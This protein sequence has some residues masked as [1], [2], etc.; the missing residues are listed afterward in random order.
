MILAAGLGKRMM[1]ITEKTPKALIKIGKITLLENCI[2]RLKDFGIEEI[3]INKS[4]E[5]G[6]RPR[7]EIGAV[8]QAKRYIDMGVKDFC[9][10]WDRFILRATLAQLGEGLTKAL[11]GI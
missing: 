1:P 2:L 5:Y 10:G 4:L 9:I 11:E 8:E 7:I 6:L 3:V